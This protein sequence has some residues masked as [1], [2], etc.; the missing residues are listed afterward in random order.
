VTAL[1]AF[2]EDILELAVGAEGVLRPALEGLLEVSV[3][4][5]E[6]GMLVSDLCCW[7]LLCLVHSEYR[8]EHIPRRT[9]WLC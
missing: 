8:T 1:E 7:V 3:C 6:M 2:R 9:C 5:L 4:A